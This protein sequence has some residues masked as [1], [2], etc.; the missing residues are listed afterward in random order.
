MKPL[1]CVLL[2]SLFAFLMWGG[3]C[4]AD[5][6]DAALAQ[7][8]APFI[9]TSLGPHDL[10]FPNLGPFDKVELYPPINWT[11]FVSASDLVDA[12]GAKIKSAGTWTDFKDLETLG[13]DL[14]SSDSTDFKLIYHL[15]EGGPDWSSVFAGAGVYAHVQHLEMAPTG[16]D[17]NEPP[18]TYLINIDYTILWQNNLES[19]YPN[20]F[21]HL[22]DLTFLAV[23]YDPTSDRI[24]RL[25]YPA[26]GC[27][28]Q[29]FQTV[30]DTLPNLNN[31]VPPP[32]SQPSHLLKAAHL[33][34]QDQHNQTIQSDA[35]EVGIPQE[36]EVDV[37]DN[38]CEWLAFRSSALHVFFVRDPASKTYD[39]PAIYAE[40][41][42]HESF[43]NADTGTITGGGIHNG[44]GPSWIPTA[45]TMLPE[46]SVLTDND[47]NGPFLHYG[48]KVGE[49]GVTPP[50]HGTWCWN[51]SLKPCAYINP[52]P[53]ADPSNGVN[54]PWWNLTQFSDMMPYQNWKQLAWPQKLNTARTGDAFVV[55]Q[56]TQGNGTKDSPYGGLEVAL[57]FVPKGWTLHLSQGSYQAS[58]LKRP[59]TLEA[60]GLPVI[61]TRDTN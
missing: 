51:N 9:K 14:T 36:D 32:L 11:D 53:V 23:L 58:I 49:D 15:P 19:I 41:D 45:V 33:T 55:P 26:H 47:V 43:P 35:I 17:T 6:T 59:L 42:N 46:F 27:L 7:R 54:F 28:L 48:G 37:T 24:V 61:V 4:A 39:H 44:N 57:T 38:G 25:T 12:N 18:Q 5:Q 31:S 1:H 52:H 10:A 29:I 20:T 30:P 13:S 16:A 60:T 3:A 21:N 50:L 34:G 40:F 22:G 8:F 56:Q 2:A